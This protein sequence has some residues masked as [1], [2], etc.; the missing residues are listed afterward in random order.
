MTKRILERKHLVGTIRYSPDANYVYLNNPK[1]ACSTVK[2]A[3]WNMEKEARRIDYLPDLWQLHGLGFWSRD[4][5]FQNRADVFVFT[6]VRNP[7]SRIL[8]AYLD[9]IARIGR[10]NLIRDIFCRLY[11]VPNDKEISFRYFLEAIRHSPSHYDDPHWRL[12]S[13]NVLFD[14]IR[15]DFIGHLENIDYDLPYVLNR[16]S[17]VAS[18][19][20]QQ[21]HKTG[22]VRQLTEVFGREEIDIVLEKYAADFGNFGYG[23]DLSVAKP[24]GPAMTSHQEPAILEFLSAISAR[25]ATT[26]AGHEHIDKAIALDEGNPVYPAY[27][28]SLLISARKFDQA[29]LFARRTVNID[30]E[31][32]Q[33]H[34]MLASALRGAQKD[35]AGLA[36]ARRAVSLACHQHEY[37]WCLATLLFRKGLLAKAEKAILTAM[38]MADSEM[39]RN[40][41]LLA[42]I[43]SAQGTHKAAVRTCERILVMRQPPGAEVLLVLSAL[44]VKAG[45]R[46]IAIEMLNKARQ[47]FSDNAPVRVELAAMLRQVDC[48]DKA[49]EVLDEALAIDPKNRRAQMEMRNCSAPPKLPLT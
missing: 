8:S 43:Q 44:Y 17:C 22:A 48:F 42:Q 40:Y 47:E 23:S 21:T 33:G 19:E 9:K 18:F 39:V 16:I 26:R 49:R 28:A 13:D 30:K 15:I 12:Q 6:I 20:A 1:C 46:V 38:E 25:N 14:A 41:L 36:H 2:Y 10:E 24:V 4:Y 35:A 5:D 37:W 11:D 34:Y 27:K 31:Y 45:R 29:R 3:L 7:F 32:A